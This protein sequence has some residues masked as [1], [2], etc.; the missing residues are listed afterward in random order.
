MISP[1]TKLNIR[2]ALPKVK[3]NKKYIKRKEKRESKRKEEEE[4]EFNALHYGGRGK[5]KKAAKKVSAKKQKDQSKEVKKKKERRPRTVIA[6]APTGKETLLKVKAKALVKENKTKKHKAP[7]IRDVK[8]VKN[9]SDEKP[10]LV[11]KQEPAENSEKGLLR[12]IIEGDSGS[13]SAG[14]FT[15][16]EPDFATPVEGNAVLSEKDVL[17]EANKYFES[18]SKKERQLNRAAAL[19][20]KKLK[21]INR[22]G[23][24]KDGFRYVLPKNTKE[25]VRQ[26]MLKEGTGAVID[27]STLSSSFG[28]LSSAEEE[29]DKPMRKSRRHGGT[30]NDFYQFQVSKRWTRNAERFL[31]RGRVDKSLFESKKRQRSIKKL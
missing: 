24:D 20:M 14:L 5:I 18:L 16:T 8:V 26:M 29:S 1:N 21:E 13:S 11:G 6:N 3:E 30:Y 22:R 9:H 4:K 12:R 15:S 27:P 28:A 10:L 25:L 2:D 23:G 19:H 31:F 17:A 7:T